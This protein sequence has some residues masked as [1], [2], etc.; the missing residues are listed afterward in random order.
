MTQTVQMLVWGE[1]G[2]LPFS[3]K[4]IAVEGGLAVT[5]APWKRHR[6]TVTHIE[7][8]LG[9]QP[10]KID[11]AAAKRK[12]ALEAFRELLALDVDWTR[13]Q[14]EVKAEVKQKRL[15]RRIMAIA[16]RVA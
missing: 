10:R 6:Y 2:T 11:G 12:V 4:A 15:K 16:E 7:S 13:T 9:I 14:P 3:A 1:L 8:G 5:E